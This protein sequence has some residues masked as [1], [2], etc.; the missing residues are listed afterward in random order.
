MFVETCAVKHKYSRAIASEY[1]QATVKPLSN[2][3]I[4]EIGRVFR[5][6]V[7]LRIL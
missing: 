1:T 2:Q 7:F 4:H 3:Y 5:Y 6:A